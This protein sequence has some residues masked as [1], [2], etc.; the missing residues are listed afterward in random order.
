MRDIWFQDINQVEEAFSAWGLEFTYDC[1]KEKRGTQNKWF[2]RNIQ[3][4]E[5]VASRTR[6]RLDC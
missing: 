6:S 2:E 4:V 3:Q 1:T 5:R